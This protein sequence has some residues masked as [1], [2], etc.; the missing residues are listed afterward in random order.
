M[1]KMEAES[2]TEWLS[3]FTAVLSAVL[4]LGGLDLS[5]FMNMDN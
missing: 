2:E 5:P 1:G 4:V 3:A